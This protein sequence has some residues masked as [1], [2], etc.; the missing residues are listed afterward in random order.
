[1]SFELDRDWLNEVCESA[2]SDG[3]TLLKVWWNQPHECYYASWKGLS[4]E[5][6]HNDKYEDEEDKPIFQKNDYCFEF[7]M[8][9]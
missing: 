6:Q 2:K 8:K 7:K 5:D 3:A 4:L 9:I 1:M